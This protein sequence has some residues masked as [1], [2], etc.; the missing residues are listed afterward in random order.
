M[1]VSPRQVQKG[2][3]G[4]QAVAARDSSAHA[5][6]ASNLGYTIRMPGAGFAVTKSARRITRLGGRL[7]HEDKALANRKNRKQTKQELQ[8]RMPDADITPKLWT[9]WDLL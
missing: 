1:H 5:S 8:T 9:D 2:E 7:S 3:G 6:G 4:H